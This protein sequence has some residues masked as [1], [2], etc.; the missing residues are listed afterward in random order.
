[1]KLTFEL[2]VASFTLHYSQYYLSM[3]FLK[4][5]CFKSSK[6]NI[7]KNIKI[8]MKTVMK[9]VIKMNITNVSLFPRSDFF[10]L[11]LLCLILYRCYI[12]KL[13]HSVVLRNYSV[14]LIHFLTVLVENGGICK[15]TRI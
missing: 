5:Y 1:M 15:Y 14:I 3:F 8:L 11:N 9:I 2:A 4:H 13:L 7:N 12:F 6:G 10:F